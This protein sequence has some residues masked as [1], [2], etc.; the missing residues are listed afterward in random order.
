MNL[1][2]LTTL[3]ASAAALAC[4]AAL[5]DGEASEY[6]E[7]SVTFGGTL[8]DG[9]TEDESANLAF[10]FKNVKDG[11]EYILGA[12]G[13]VTRTTT[14]NTVTDSE[15]NTSTRK[16]KKTTA[17]NGE[18]KGKVIIPVAEPF[19][20]Y[21]D[22]SAFRDEI[23]DIDYRFMVG[24]GVVWDVVKTDD[25]GFALELGI[26]PMWEK[27]D[28]ETE[29]Y[30]MLRLG[31][32]VEKKLGKGAKIWESVEYLPAIDDS[33]KYLVNAECGVESPLADNLSLHVTLKDKYNSLPADGNEKNDVSLIVGVR[34]KL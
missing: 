33:D 4:T 13:T 18:L 5:A 1:K 19:S 24:P 11:Y 29:Y 8:N 26:A 32:R 31:E 28:G 9:N 17:K 25:F 22:A 23:A 27:T 2:T 34:V 30:T 16:S 7:T 14:E 6:P 10:D 15:G 12:N 20:A 3:A 21:F